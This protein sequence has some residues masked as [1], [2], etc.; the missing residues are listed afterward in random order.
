MY[1]C[2]D[3]VQWLGD[4]TMP[5]LAGIPPTSVNSGRSYGIEVDFEVLSGFQESVSVRD[6]ILFL[7]KDS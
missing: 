1:M 6:T 3:V 5:T 4:L 7:S 2:I